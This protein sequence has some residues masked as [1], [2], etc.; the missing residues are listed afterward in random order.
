MAQ[1]ILDGK[2]HGPHAFIVPIRDLKTH[3]PLPG[4]TVGDVGPKF[5]LNTLDNGFVLFDHV[6]VPHENMLAKYSHVVKASGSYERPPNAKVGY[7]TMTWVRANI[8]MYARLV[9]ARA[10]TVAIR[11]TAIRRQFGDKDAPIY[12]HGQVL[13]TPTLD[14]TMVL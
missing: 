1:L 7:G 10:A 2:S 13:E 12:V 4:V 8:V 11:Y 5:G 9:L 3:K 6:R 14:Y